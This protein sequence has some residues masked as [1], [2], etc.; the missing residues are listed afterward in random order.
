[1]KL[2]S[3]KRPQDSCMHVF[4][5]ASESDYNVV[6]Y[7]TSAEMDGRRLLLLAKSSAFPLKTISKPRR[8]FMA[9]IFTVRTANI[10]KG[11]S[12]WKS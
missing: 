5:H 11:C 4:S 9:V 12:D 6:A 2:S 3:K 7:D 10:L 8:D 1:M